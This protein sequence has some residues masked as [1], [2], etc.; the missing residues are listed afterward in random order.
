MK[1]RAFFLTKAA[2]AAVFQGDK[3]YIWTHTWPQIG[4][5]YVGIIWIST[6]PTHIY[7]LRLNIFTR[8]KWRILYIVCIPQPSCRH[9]NISLCSQKALY[10]TQKSPC[11]SGFLWSTHLANPVLSEF[12][13][14][15]EHR[16]WSPDTYT[17]IWQIH[18]KD[19][20][21]PLLTA[22]YRPA[23][24]YISTI[25]RNGCL[26]VLAEEKSCIYI[27][28]I[29]IRNRWNW[30]KTTYKNSNTRYLKKSPTCNGK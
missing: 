11:H 22:L 29:F 7:F 1:V 4:W 13:E 6:W 30:N 2:I 26:N 9:P 12:N 5:K 14:L 27:S 28:E 23:T 8:Q 24:K 3:K 18:T 19:N 21:N 10:S 15:P 25:L 17:S 20:N 16:L